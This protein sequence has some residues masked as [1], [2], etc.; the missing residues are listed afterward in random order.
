M[1]R[2]LIGV[3]A[4]LVL[5]AGG[6]A[7]VALLT[8]PTLAVAQQ[9]DAAAQ[10]E[11][12]PGMERARQWLF[13]ATAHLVPTVVTPEQQAAMVGA[14]VDAGAEHFREKVDHYRHR[15]RRLFGAAL[16]VSA[17]AI[18][19]DPEFLKAEVL[20]GETIASVAEDNGVAVQV[21]IDELV[22]AAEEA[23]DEKVATA[24]RD[25]DPERVA[26][27]KEKLPEIAERF[28]NGNWGDRFR[29]FADHAE[30]AGTTG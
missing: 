8:A 13:D 4:M 2:I 7:A 1:R 10:T 22:A 20:A 3:S 5:V 29:R 19:I 28:V 14:I 9:T 30:E 26:K 15:A 11:E 24:D 17:G 6:V 25:I 23:I 21:V 27:L 18:G 16:E 12:Y